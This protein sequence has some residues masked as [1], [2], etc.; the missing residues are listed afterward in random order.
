[1]EPV[2]IDFHFHANSKK[3][4]GVKILRR[5]AFEIINVDV[6]LPKSSTKSLLDKK[7]FDGFT[8]TKLSEGFAK[9]IIERFREI[10]HRGSAYTTAIE[11]D[12]DLTRSLRL[13]LKSELATISSV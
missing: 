2:I 6:L 10:E 13:N 9:K 12:F 11:K 3:P 5:H 1:D 8:L 4:V 7:K